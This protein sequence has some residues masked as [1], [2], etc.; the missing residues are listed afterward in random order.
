MRF[1]PEVAGRLQIPG[2]CVGL[3]VTGAGGEILFVEATYM[4]GKGELKITGSVGDVMHESAQTAVGL[5]RSRAR[6]LGI[7]PALFSKSNLHIHVPAGATPKDGPSAGVAIVV[8][9]TSVLL[10][11][12]VPPNL[13][14]T[15][16]ITLRGKV[17]PVGGIKEKTLAAKRAGITHVLLPVQN[18]KDLVEIPEERLADMKLDPIERI[19][20]VLSIVFGKD[21]FG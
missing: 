12:P 1:E 4:P 6:E 2:V 10:D 3:A 9:L 7:D 17:L 8:A 21:V 18:K 15:G 19:E 20:E 16:E 13:A 14:M 11:R 5:V